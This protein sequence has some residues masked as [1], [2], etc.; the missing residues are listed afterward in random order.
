MLEWPLVRRF[1][2][3]LGDGSFSIDLLCSL[4]G[5]SVR[6]L[7]SWRGLKL[8]HVPI[9][10]CSNVTKI[11]LTWGQ[12]TE[13]ISQLCKLSFFF[14]INVQILNMFPS[15]FG[16][17]S[18]TDMQDY[19]INFATSLNPNGPTVGPTWPQ[20]NSSSP[21]SLMFLDG[22]IPRTLTPDT[23]RQAPMDLLNSLALSYPI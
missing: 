18:G 7:I 11:S 23:Y 20:W 6:P 14:H 3:H 21:T 19:A 4:L 17:G 13:V 8:S 16:T 15:R 1:F 5:H 9:S 10:Q 22:L 12:C 2:K